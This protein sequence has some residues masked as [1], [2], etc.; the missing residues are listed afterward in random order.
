MSERVHMHEK[1]LAN[2]YDIK[3]ELKLM[4]KK[5]KRK[6][7]IETAKA[8]V[9]M[10]LVDGIVSSIDA[11]ETKAFGELGTEPLRPSSA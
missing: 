1:G 11:A 6:S 2:A 7:I 10:H 8:K 3:T 9:G 4:E 5:Q